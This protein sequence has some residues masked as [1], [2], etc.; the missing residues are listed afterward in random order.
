MSI[1]SP[2]TKQIFDW[3]NEIFLNKVHLVKCINARISKTSETDASM[4]SIEG[5]SLFLYSN[6]FAT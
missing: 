6:S 3:I 1:N 2:Q 5:S 4:L